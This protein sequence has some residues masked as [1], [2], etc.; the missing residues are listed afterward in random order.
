MAYTARAPLK[1]RVRAAASVRSATNASAP[2]FVNACKRSAL[3]PI[4]RTG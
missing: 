4:T 2:C 1:A 3:R